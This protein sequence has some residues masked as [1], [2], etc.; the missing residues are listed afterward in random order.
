MEIFMEDARAVPELRATARRS[1]AGKFVAFAIISFVLPTVLLFGTAGRLDWLWGW[2]FIGTWLGFGIGA[3][4]VMLIIDP[5][6]LV[7]RAESLDAENVK[8]WDRLLMPIIGLFLPFATLILVGLDQRFGLSP[9]LPP[10]TRITAFV[11]FILS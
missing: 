8:W 9:Q 10:A 3:R 2:I 7:E 5:E 4:L 11:V 1:L 6:V